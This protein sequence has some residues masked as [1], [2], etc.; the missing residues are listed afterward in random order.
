MAVVY[1]ASFVGA[2]DDY[3]ETTCP[4]RCNE[5]YS[6]VCGKKGDGVKQIFVNSCH[7]SMENCHKPS[8]EGSSFFFFNFNLSAETVLHSKHLEFILMNEFFA[9]FCV[10]VVV[11]LI[12]SFIS[13]YHSTEFENCPNAD[14]W[15]DM[16][17]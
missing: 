5:Q 3:D 14:A 7:M 17:I 1:C 10:V 9:F 12:L 6:P 11:S 8:N 13:V 4:G 2:S 15:M 16:D